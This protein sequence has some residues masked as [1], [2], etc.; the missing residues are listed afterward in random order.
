MAW[1]RLNLHEIDAALA[2]VGAAPS[3]RLDAAGSDEPMTADALRRL[4]EGYRHVDALLAERTE[5]FRYG[6]TAAILEIN[7][8]VLCGVTPERRRQYAE[9]IAAT[10]RW[11]YD[12]PGAGIGALL[13]W[14]QRHRTDPPATLAA[15]LFVQV[16]S[17][18]Q[19]FIE[20][21][22]RTA[23]LLASYVLA[24]AGRP[25]LVITPPDFPAYRALAERGSAVHR[26]GLT[27]AF[28]LAG[29]TSS[30]TA[31]IARAADPRFLSPAASVAAR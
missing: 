2:A 20:G 31:L 15:G 9:H 30:V 5:V 26:T 13:D 24:R 27:S 6:A 12:R 19:L 21:N 8:R 17:H 28:A 7:H 16:V 22:G 1:A 11:F 23:V 25:P 4:G 14:L 10:E 18:P 3:V 29:A